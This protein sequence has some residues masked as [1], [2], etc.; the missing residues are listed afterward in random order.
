V[1]AHDLALAHRDAAK[2]LIEIF[3]DADPDQQ[4]LG[5][6]E[7]SLAAHSLGIGPEF[8]DRLRIGCEPGEAVSC[9]LLRLEP[10][11]G[12]PALGGHPRP[13]AAARLLNEPSDRLRGLTCAGDEVRRSGRGKV[14]GG[15]GR[16]LKVAAHHKPRAPSC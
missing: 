1:Q 14:Q 8:P 2:N 10:L 7:A 3:A 12:D 16:L 9:V 11:G 15:H 5:F 6:P 13:N 4:F